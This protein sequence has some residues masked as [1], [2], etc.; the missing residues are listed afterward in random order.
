LPDRDL[1]TADTAY[2]FYCE[3]LV[4]SKGTTLR[5]PA[6]SPVLH[7]LWLGTPPP[8]LPARAPAADAFAEELLKTALLIPLVLR[9]AP[10]E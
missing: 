8:N 3:L 5:Q 2:C 10:P 4:A 7:L 1:R 9:T 6:P